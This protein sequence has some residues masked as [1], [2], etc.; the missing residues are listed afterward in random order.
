MGAGGPGA[1]SHQQ[2]GGTRERNQPGFP[3]LLSCPKRHTK[4]AQS[5]FHNCPIQGRKRRNFQ[6]EAKPGKHFFT[7]FARDTGGHPESHQLTGLPQPGTATKK[8]MKSQRLSLWCLT[9]HKNLAPKTKTR[10]R[11]TGGAAG[12]KRGSDAQ[13]QKN[14]RWGAGAHPTSPHISTAAEF[15]G[16]INAKSVVKVYQRGRA[17]A[18]DYRIEMSLFSCICLTQFYLVAFCTISC[19]FCC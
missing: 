9:E 3:S 16:K 4:P 5:Q 17:S 11:R 13:P 8:E 19:S 6:S 18:P 1:T 10:K 12:E 14:R 2:G 15:P 7:Q